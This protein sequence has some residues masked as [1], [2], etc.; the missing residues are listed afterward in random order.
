[1]ATNYI[2]PGKVLDLTAP[3]QRNKGE[4][5]V[6]GNLFGVAL[7]TV[8]NGA[9]G[10]FAIEGCWTL[11]KATGAGWTQGQI[12]YW[13]NTNKNVTGT[14]TS[15]YRIGCAIAAAASGDTTGQVRLNGQAVPTGA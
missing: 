2:Q 9:V 13:D 5:A 6:I 11:A 1:M 3:Y 12:L 8:A 10:Q 7:S 14:S 4:G 15:N